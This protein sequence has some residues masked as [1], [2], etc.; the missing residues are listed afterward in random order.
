MRGWGRF[1]LG[2]IR[3]HAAAH[4]AHG[5]SETD[6]VYRVSRAGITWN[7]SIFLHAPIAPRLERTRD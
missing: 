6:S 5:K 2:A 4:A 3:G 7:S 1:L